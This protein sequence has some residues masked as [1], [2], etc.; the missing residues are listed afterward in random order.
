MRA[1]HTLAIGIIV[2][3]AIS[4]CTRQPTGVA[5]AAQAMGATNLNSIQYSG[6]GSTFAFG[7]AASPG[8]RWPRFEAKYATPRTTVGELAMP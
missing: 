2:T 4:G 5:A 8:E 6:S 1:L 7:Q 3:V